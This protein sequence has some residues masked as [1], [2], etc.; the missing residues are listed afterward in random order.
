[1]GVHA[2]VLAPV[3][4]AGRRRL[5]HA[6]LL[7]AVGVSLASCASLGPDDG[8]ASDVVA[9]TAPPASVDPG[10]SA[11]APGLHE[12][13]VEGGGAAHAVRVVVPTGSTGSRAPVVIGF[14]GLGATGPDQARLSGYEALAEREGFIAVHPTSVVDGSDGGIAWQLAPGGD[15]RDDVAFTVALID[16]LV[17]GWC[18][19]PDRVFVT[20]MSNGGFFVARLVCELSDR[21]AAAVSVA[22]MFRPDGCAPAR[23]VP[24]LAFHGTADEFVPFDGD[25]ESL[26]LGAGGSLPAELFT[27]DMPVTFAEFAAGAGCDPAPIDTVVDPLVDGGRGTMVRHTYSGCD[28]GMPM[29]FV[30]VVGGGHTWPGAGGVAAGALDATV[31]GWAFMRAFAL[32]SDGTQ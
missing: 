14:H 20:G 13:I 6:A 9:P 32:P 12:V 15:G 29:A 21:I 28:G 27:T 16:E 2:R 24:Y 7:A 18:A 23:V 31:D 1:M 26:L 25:G 5:R 11:G 3:T 4:A 22:G 8:D 10:C 17:A 19:D 30:E